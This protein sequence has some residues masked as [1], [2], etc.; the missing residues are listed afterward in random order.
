MSSSARFVEE[1][2][3]QYEKEF[4]LKSSLESR[5][6]NIITASGTIAGFLL[7]FGTFLLGGLDKSSI[8]SGY[9][10]GS[11][12]GGIATAMTAISFS[13]YASFLRK[14]SYALGDVSALTMED[15][16]NKKNRLPNE[17]QIKHFTDKNEDEFIKEM[18]IAYTKSIYNND[19]KNRNKAIAVLIG[20]CA[21]FISI[22]F[23]LILIVLLIQAFNAGQFS[24]PPAS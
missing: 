1:L 24:L 3:M 8:L 6:S 12:I 21:I 17:V 4:E 22:I 18:I 5:A 16:N 23:A 19:S 11:L 9:V 2:R 15:R 13:I 10:T 14:Y 20:Q 7:V